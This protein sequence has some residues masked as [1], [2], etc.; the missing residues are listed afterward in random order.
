MPHHGHSMERGL[1]VEQHEVSILEAAFHDHALIDLLLDDF[2][3]I[4]VV[5]V[6]ALELFLPGLGVGDRNDDIS[7]SILFGQLNDPFV[8]VLSDLLW[9]GELVGDNLRDAQLVHTKIG[10]GRDD[11]SGAKVDPLTHEILAKASL[12]ALKSGANTLERLRGRFGFDFSCL[13]RVYDFSD[14]SH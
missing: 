8:I 7:D 9:D 11:G 2:I 14:F 6:E 10:I 4:S 13:F 5:E 12:L 3:V 1:P